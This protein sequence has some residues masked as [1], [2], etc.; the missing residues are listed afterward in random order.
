M[1]GGA[2]RLAWILVAASATLTAAPRGTS[3]P[4][5]AGSPVVAPYELAVWPLNATVLDAK[6]Q[7][8][9]RGKNIMPANPCSDEVFIRRVYLDLLGTLPE[10]AEVKRFLQD[11]RLGR[12]TYLVDTLLTR[13]EYAEYFAMRW[14][15]VLRVKAEF[16]INLW[17]NAVQAY[18]RWLR[19]AI[20]DNKPYDQFAREMLTASGSNFRVAPVNFYRAM[21]GR[22]PSTIAGCVALAFMGSRLETWPEAQRR[23]MTAFFTRL[24]Y[25]PTGE[26]KEEIV[27]LDPAPGG[28]L[29]AVFPDGKAVKVPDGTDPRLVFADWLLTPGNPWFARAMV[30]R[31]WYWLMGRGIVHEPDDMRPD[32]PPANPELLA[33]LEKDLVASGYD[34]KAL[35]RRIVNSRTYQQ[36]SIPRSKD[37]ATEALFGVYPVRRLDAE[38]LS[39]ALR[40]IT[41]AGETF[42]SNVP[43][44]FTFLPE[45]Q[46]AIGVADGTI[47]TPFLEL[48]GRPARDTGLESER[49]N[50]PT[51]AQ[52]LHLINSSDVHRRLERSA[53]LRELE[54]GNW[55][56]GARQEVI[57]GVY[58]LILSRDP[59]A[60]ELEVALKHCQGGGMAIHQAVVDLAWALINTKEFLYRH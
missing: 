33:W 1:R 42:S 8:E 60:N 32:N 23:G 37:P 21:Q 26:W 10:P 46:R 6:V 57:R 54:K 34:P 52:R 25:K 24:K 7:A 14:C 51:D 58:L 53:H 36:S 55:K 40:W 15:D 4:Q 27:T 16:P 43:E 28:E 5:P 31:M 59:T 11:K 29:E 2:R 39:D 17:P 22:E 12:R 38:V 3:T 9:L 44:P 20:R 45:G 41:G 49:N 18:H 13:P 19:D 50:N 30:N 48:F 47:S 35:I 56:P